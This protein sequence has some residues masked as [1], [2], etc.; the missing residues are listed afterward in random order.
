MPIY[1]IS[2]GISEA[3]PVWPGDPP[4]S[5]TQPSRLDRGDVFTLTR[6][7][8]SVHT[9]THVDAPAHFIPGG[10]GV[11][12]LDL[13]VLIGPALMVDAGETDAIT[14]GVLD[15]LAVPAGTERLLLRTRNSALWARGTPHFVED[16]VA[17]TADG[18]RW[19]VDRGVKLVGVDYLSVA[20]YDD[21]VSTHRV[22]L[23]AGII[24][25]EGLSLGHV[26]PGPYRL[27]CLPLKIQGSDG[28]PARAILID[29]EVAE[30]R[31]AERGMQNAEGRRQIA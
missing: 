23:G 9:G 22:L 27:V 1:D 24:V 31:N 28:A 6:M 7:D 8:V 26:E 3:L 10:A 4:V 11:D 18:A 29:D 2:L 21:L 30:V 12:S 5:L 25:A 17:I 14:A 20:P 15:G 16:F 19:L 13:E